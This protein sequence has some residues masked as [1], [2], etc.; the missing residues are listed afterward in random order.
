VF[1][2]S[3]P[4][5]FSRGCRSVLVFHLRYE[6]RNTERNVTPP[7]NKYIQGIDLAFFR[8]VVAQ[9]SNASDCLS[10]ITKWVTQNHWKNKDLKAEDGIPHHSTSPKLDQT[11]AASPNII[12]KPYNKLCTIAIVVILGVLTGYVEIV[13]W[14]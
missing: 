9:F 14:W 13:N 7:Q 8:E 5:L 3:M 2:W 4:K 12:I 6:K 1:Q 11:T 10:L